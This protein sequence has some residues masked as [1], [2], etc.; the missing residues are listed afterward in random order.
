MQHN[1]L[2]TKQNAVPQYNI[3]EKKNLSQ[4]VHYGSFSEN[5]NFF[6]SLNLTQI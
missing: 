3:L 1:D 6:I 5:L 2:E 4:W